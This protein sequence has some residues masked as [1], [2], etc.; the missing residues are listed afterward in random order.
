MHARKDVPYDVEFVSSLNEI[1]KDT[2]IKQTKKKEQ[3]FNLAYHLWN[4]QE[5]KERK[6]KNS[7]N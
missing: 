7:S 6:T 3:L 4:K 5:E 1:K 2:D